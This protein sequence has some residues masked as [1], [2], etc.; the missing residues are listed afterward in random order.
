MNSYF[1]VSRRE[2]DPCDIVPF[3]SSPAPGL[4]TAS[5]CCLGKKKFTSLSA[6]S[7]LSEPCRALMPVSSQ[8]SKN[9]ALRLGDGALCWCY[10]FSKRA[11]KGLQRVLQIECFFFSSE[12]AGYKG[13][14]SVLLL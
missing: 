10:N 12:G 8:S 7:K 3:S 1:D 9:W 14:K 2:R 5:V 11:V 4:I 6:L 13:A